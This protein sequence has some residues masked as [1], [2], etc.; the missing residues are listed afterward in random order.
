MSWLK[1]FNIF[2]IWKKKGINGTQVREIHEKFGLDLVT[3][4]ILT[5]RGITSDEDIK[6]FLEKDTAF[7]HNPFLFDDMEAAVDR[8]KDAISEGEKIHICGD[9][10]ADGITSTVLLKQ[11]LDAYFE[12]CTWSVPEG[13]EPYGLT[14]ERV[15]QL[16]AQQVTLIITVDCGISN[17]EEIALAS[18]LGIDTIILDHHLAS[19]TLPPAYAIID[20]KIEG[21]GYP[22][23]H[24]AGCGVVAK[25][26]WA[27]RFS[28]TDWYAQ[29][30]VL[31]HAHPGNGTMVIE[32]VLLENL[33]ET[34]RV[35]EEIVPGIIQADQTR[36]FEILQNRQILV[37][38]KKLEE[39]QL[40]IAFG[41]S[42]DINVMDAAPSIWNVFP[43]LTN[44]SL[45]RLKNL[46]HKQKYISGEIREIDTFIHLFNAFVRKK[47]PSLSSK[48]DNLMDFVAIGTVAD[49]MPMKDE[50]RIMVR[51]GLQILEDAKRDSLR[52][53][54]MEKNL[55]GKRLSTTDIG[56]QISPVFNATGRMGVP[57]IAVSL[58]LSDNTLELEQLTKEMIRL[59]KERKKIGGDAW[60]RILP[61]ASKNFK[62]NGE[63]IVI[64]EDKQLNRG[65]T[66]IIASRLL[67]SF[68]APAMVV[69]HL[70]DERLI[71]SMRSGKTLNVKTFLDTFNDILIDHGGHSCAGGFSLY[72]KDRSEFFD[73]VKHAASVIEVRDQEIVLEV[74]AELPHDYMKPELI[75][76]VE[77]LEPYGEENPPLQFLVKKT[78]I[79]E[80]SILGNGGE[81]AHLRI[82][83]SCGG[84]KWPAV[85]WKASERVNRDFS[86]GDT[87]DVVFRLGRNYFKN[88]ESLQLTILD[89]NRDGT[90][91]LTNS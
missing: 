58:L 51:K 47:E 53:F 66:G 18:G 65:I 23:P 14:K 32:A 9:R 77:L 1:G 24:L 13:D 31:L 90:E 59:N 12:D 4:S 91:I 71:G 83:L 27:L 80:I 2:M 19:D 82:L 40:R 81:Q 88:S 52:I 69:A 43:K 29:E 48:Y 68:N 21:C 36:L 89:I 7:L 73:R 15:E 20:P 3:S 8:V 72:Q 74:D 85:F 45:V 61:K 78:K 17:H 44:K 76:V 37:Y 33:L 22:F 54:L 64:I 11:E 6:F 42:V 49:L 87:V 86:K 84:H 5:R 67:F 55:F 50:N 41:E 57:S 38:D 62:E 39:R 34:Q 75:D 28:L 60:D 46:S 56:W 25:F 70:D 16:Y 35:I 26:I 79:E 30:I 10:D 63:R